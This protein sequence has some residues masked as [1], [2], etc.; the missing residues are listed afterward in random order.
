MRGGDDGVRPD[1]LQPLI[2]LHLVVIL[3]LAETEAI[4]APHGDQ[5]T[6]LL[7][8]EDLVAHE[9]HIL[10]PGRG[11]D[12][13]REGREDVA[14]EAV[15]TRPAD[16]LGRLFAAGPVQERAVKIDDE[17][18]RTRLRLSGRGVRGLLEVGGCGA[19]SW[20]W[21]QIFRRIEG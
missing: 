1:C 8:R 4:A 18:E 21:G 10:G 20:G 15:E 14:D 2:D 19:W 12:H 17:K 13:G 11:P 7:V 5:V 6:A 3:L 9:L 16:E